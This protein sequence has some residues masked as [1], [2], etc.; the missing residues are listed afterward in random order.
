MTEVG[1]YEARTHLKRLLDQVAKGEEIIITRRGVP[2]AQLVPPPRSPH[3]VD[4]A[5]VI[6][7]LEEF[8]RGNRLGDLSIR[9]LIDEGRE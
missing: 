7:E 2:V 8:R 5:S 9:D 6:K 1:A 4:V 3:D